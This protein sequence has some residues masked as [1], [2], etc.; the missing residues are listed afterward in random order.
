[1]CVCVR[2]CVCV[3]VCQ[4]CLVC[5]GGVCFLSLWAA[6]ECERLPR[7][8]D[9]LHEVLHDGLAQFHARFHH[10]PGEI[11]LRVLKH[12][13]HRTLLLVVVCTY[14]SRVSIK[15]HPRCRRCLAYAQCCG[16]AL[17]LT[18]PNERSEPAALSCLGTFLLVKRHAP[19]P[20]VVTQQHS[21]ALCN[22]PSTTSAPG[23]MTV[24]TRAWTDLWFSRR[25]S[26]AGSR[27]WD[28]AGS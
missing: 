13:V 20:L 25:R 11:M 5:A 16:T 18:N 24:P 10:Q 21:S 9:L 15:H 12:H 8:A 28:G 23:W 6:G 7:H 2:V 19:C 27:C 17:P 4:S 3:C 22:S 1:V 26:R 14:R